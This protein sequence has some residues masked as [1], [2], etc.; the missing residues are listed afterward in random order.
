MEKDIKNTVDK[1]IHKYGTSVDQAIPILQAIQDEFNYLPEEAISYLCEN[2]EITPARAYGISTFYT[3]FRH[4][5]V[6][7]HMIKVCVGTACHVKGAKQ[8]FDAFKRELNIPDDGETDPDGLFTIEEVACLG[9]CTIAPVVQIDDITYGHLTTEKIKETLEDFIQAKDNPKSAYS[10]VG[11]SQEEIQGEIRLGLGSCCVASGSDLVKQEL[12]DVLDKT[13]IHVDVKQV[14]C[15]GICNQVPMLE[16]HKQGED[17]TFYTKIKAEEVSGVIRKHFKPNRFMDRLRS[18]FYDYF[19]G[20]VFNEIPK[21]TARYESEQRDTPVSEFLEKQINIATEYRG[22]IKPTDLDEYKSLGG[23]TTF[24]KCVEEL[25]PEEIIDIVKDSGLKGRGGGGFLTGLKWE[26][27][28]KED[29]DKKYL[30]CNGDEGDPGAFMDRM[31]LESYPF[32]VIEGLLIAAYA[33]GA[34]EGLFYIRAE[35]PLA[36]KRI[37]EALYMCREEGFIGENILGSDFSFYINI[38][39]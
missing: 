15:V 32:R 28:A 3:Q 16:I 4:H 27:V 17:P 1:V 2:T 30:I 36:V 6:G 25:K 23:F 24:R 19:E 13:N 22:A 7:K 5:P 14:G 39:V 12:E 33:V 37:R 38:R 11:V 31:L 34:S 20:I 8:V 21:S 29:S 18:N 35:Y 10:G 9:C 26:L